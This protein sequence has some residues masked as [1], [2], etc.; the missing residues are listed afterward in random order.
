[1]ELISRREWTR[2]VG[3]LVKCSSRLSESNENWTESTNLCKGKD[4]SSTILRKVINTQKRTPLIRVQTRS[5]TIAVNCT[6]FYQL[7]NRMSL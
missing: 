5:T 7:L 4:V 1:M 6:N 2:K 3:F